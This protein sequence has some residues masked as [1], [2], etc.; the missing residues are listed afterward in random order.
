MLA[1]IL[2]FQCKL[3]LAIFDLQVTTLLPTKF[4]VAFRCRRRNGHLG[5][6]ILT[7][8]A[9]S[10]LQVTL[11]LPTKL[12]VNWPFGSGEEAN[13]RFSRWSPQ[14][15]SWISDQNDFSC[16]WSTS[17]HAASYQ[18]SSQLVF[19][20]RR[21]ID[22]WMKVHLFICF[23]ISFQEKKQ[24]K[25]F[26]NSTHLEFPIRRILAT[27]DLQVT[28][29]LTTK[30]QV[31]WPFGSGEAAKNRFSRWPQLWPSLISN[32]NEFSYFWSTSHFEAAFQVSSQ[33]AFQSRIDWLCWG[34]TT[35]QPLWVIL[36]HLPE[37]WRKEIVKEM[38]ERNRD[39][40]DTGMIVCL[41]VLRFYSPVNPV[42][43]CRAR[44]VYLTKFQVN[45]PF[46]SGEEMKNSF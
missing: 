26:Q 8:F 22:V 44:S 7:I 37:K 15:T 5:F 16:F 2:D 4:Q 33:L 43:S 23:C 32:W 11:M 39:E 27:F 17:H 25:D 9:T 30:F 1:A 6:S 29:M 10:D 35:C 40:R 13:N 28:L 45:W 24:K 38:K 42:G 20:F 19:L 36:C 14:W 31:D 41:F 34:L 3:F 46:C 12:Q 18:I 21:R